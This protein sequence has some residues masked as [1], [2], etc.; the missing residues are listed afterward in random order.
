MR[1]AKYVIGRTSVKRLGRVSN[2][3]ESS[4]ENADVDLIVLEILR[5][6]VMSLWDQS[7]VSFAVVGFP[8]TVSVAVEMVLSVF[9]Q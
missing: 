1:V 8:C 7:L 9:G 6:P 2:K 4:P 3:V 5:F